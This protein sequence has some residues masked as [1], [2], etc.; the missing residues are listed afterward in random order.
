MTAKEQKLPLYAQATIIVVGLIA[1]FYIMLVLKSIVVPFILAVIISIVLYPVV[2]FFVKIKCNRLI[3]IIITLF[4]AFTVIAAFS[5]VIISQV[6]R[7]VESWPSLVNK[8]GELFNQSIVWI[9]AS[10][11]IS[12]DE[13]GSW[14][15]KTKKELFNTSGA[16][17]GQTLLSVGGNLALIFLMPV[18]IFMLLFYQPLIIEFIRRLFGTDKRIEVD[19][20]ITQIKTLIQGYLVGLLIQLVIMATLFSVGLLLL[21]IEYAIM[22]GILGAFLNLIPYLG[23]VSAAILPMMIAI[24]TKPSP[25]Y[26]LLVMALYIVVQFIDNNFIV[27]KIVASKVKINALVTIIAVIAL[28]FL[29]GIAGMVIAIPLLAIVKLIFDNVDGLKPWGFLLGDTM[30]P[31]LKTKPFYL[32]KN[33]T[34]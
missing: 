12:T 32:R 4:L 18:Y 1:F 15:G 5:I 30:P 33:K 11:N 17:I 26:A 25:W 7:F 2:V 8:F 14:I 23:A 16:E 31:I 24:V 10:F 9:S 20:V 19:K 27:P 21:G 6:S 34:K 13:I 3:A 22:L 29:W 28:G